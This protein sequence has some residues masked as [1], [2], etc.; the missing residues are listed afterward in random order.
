MSILLES[1][2]KESTPEQQKVP[3][4]HASHFDDDMLGDEWLLKR[5]RAWQI[6]T[7]ILFVSLVISWSYFLFVDRDARSLNGTSNGFASGTGA[8]HSSNKKEV[9]IEKSS[10]KQSALT[11]NDSSPERGTE[12]TVQVNDN[13]DISEIP[14]NVASNKNKQVYKPQKRKNTQPD[15]FSSA[16][17]VQPTIS[18]KAQDEK[19]PANN[20]TSG[21]AILFDELSIE[22]QQQ[23]PQLS[24]NSYV[25]ADNP[26]D[27]FVILDGAFYKINQIIT[28]D[29]ILRG[30][31]NEH[32]VLEYRSYLVK[33]P[34]K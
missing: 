1:L 25:V 14:E 9:M 11:N 31:T 2:N 13:Q 10:P 23:F 28:P 7:A 24:I 3:D 26:G 18:S 34:H 33:L 32:I 30:I 6:V 29:L 19:I 15:Q 22:L 4:L 27:S 16:N 12:V 21:A 17:N 5:I 20:S 8:E